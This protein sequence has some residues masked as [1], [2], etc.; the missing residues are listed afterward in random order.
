MRRNMTIIPANGT[1]LRNSTAKARIPAAAA[2]VLRGPGVPPVHR[3][4]L[5]QGAR[6]VRRVFPESEGRLG[7]RGLKVSPVL[8]VLRGLWVKPAP[9]VLRGLPVS[10][11]PQDPRD[12][13]VLPG[14]SVLKGLPGKPVQ[15]A[16]R[17]LPVSLAPQA[18]KVLP[19]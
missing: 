17:G 15:L 3:G 11:A 19:V 8:W 4:R 12:Q 10:R 1:A 13:P 5:G 6:P 18:R 2:Y 16:L 7:P 14:P 9:L